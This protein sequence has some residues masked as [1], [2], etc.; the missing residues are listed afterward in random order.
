MYPTTIVEDF[1]SD[2]DAIVKYAEDLEYS[3]SPTGHWPGVRS[4]HIG[5]I[6][7]NLFQ[8]I[9]NKIYSLF[10]STPAERCVIDMWFQLITPYHEDKWNPLNRGWVHRDTFSNFGGIIYLTKNPEKDT[11]TS[12]YKEVEG[13][14]YQTENETKNKRNHFLGNGVPEKEYSESWKRNQSQYLETVKVE[15]VYN[16]ML[17]FNSKTHHAVKTYGTKPRLTIAFFSNGEIG[18]NVYPPLYR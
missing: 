2:P 1:F 5:E 13:Y 14:Y 6:N 17:M 15:N 10:H 3:P 8:Y 11:G 18:S 16:R 9:G 12:I 4:K 7:F